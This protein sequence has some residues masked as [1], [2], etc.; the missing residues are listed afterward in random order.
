MSDA[1]EKNVGRAKQI[2]GDLIGDEELEKEGE[3][4]EAAGKAKE[5]IEA[6]GETAKRAVDAVKDKFDR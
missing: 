2:A 3:R 6:A 5:T 4:D 1:R